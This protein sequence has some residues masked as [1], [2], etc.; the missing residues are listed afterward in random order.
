[1]KARPHPLCAKRD[2]VAA[3]DVVL[4]RE[5][6]AAVVMTF[7]SSC[8]DP[9]KRRM[10]GSIFAYATEASGRSWHRQLLDY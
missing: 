10:S 6:S 4:V 5:R 8:T 2:R 1:M 9:A 3:A 7:G